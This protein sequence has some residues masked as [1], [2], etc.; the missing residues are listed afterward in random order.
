M[1]RHPPP[2]TVAKEIRHDFARGLAV[3]RHG[4]ESDVVTQSM[5]ERKATGEEQ[6]LRSIG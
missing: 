3:E 4:V 5:M 6:D 1:A 2:R